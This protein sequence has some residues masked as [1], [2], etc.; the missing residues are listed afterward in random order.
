MRCFLPRLLLRMP[1]SFWTQLVSPSHS[2]NGTQ[3]ALIFAGHFER[4]F[5][6]PRAATQDDMNLKMQGS[7]IELAERYTNMTKMYVEMRRR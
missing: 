2:H 6:A 5:L 7:I 4:H 1:F 3:Q